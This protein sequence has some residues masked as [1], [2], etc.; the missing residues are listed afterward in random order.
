MKFCPKCGKNLPHSQGIFCSECSLKSIK[1]PEIIIDLC[2][3]CNRPVKGKK[4]L[5]KYKRALEKLGKVQKIEFDGKT[6]NFE[7]EIKGQEGEVLSANITPKIIFGVCKNCSRR[8][9]HY[10][11]C[12]AQL[13]GNKADSISLIEKMRSME[14]AQEFISK[15][16]EIK[17]KKG[18]SG[19]DLY[20]SSDRL[21]Y[22][23][24]KSFKNRLK[25]KRKLTRKLVT[26]K[27]KAIY[28]TTILLNFSR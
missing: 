19:F 18:E 15:I 21:L 6:I 23:A 14:S 24:M 12:I 13:R 27:D 8:A 28:R 22:K 17:S 5:Y 20:L 16:V 9:G 11:T 7:L 2:I 10:Y 3:K 1:L 4:F 26:Y 25:Y